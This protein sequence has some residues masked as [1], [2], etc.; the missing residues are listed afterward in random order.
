MSLLNILKSL[1]RF[2]FFF[3]TCY[4]CYMMTEKKH[5]RYHAGEM[6]SVKEVENF[7]SKKIWKTS[8]KKKKKNWNWCYSS[9]GWECKRRVLMILQNVFFF[10]LSL[11][12]LYMYS[13]TS[14]IRPL[15]ISFFASSYIQPH[16]RWK[17][18]IPNEV[19]VGGRPRK[20][21]RASFLLLL[22]LFLS[23][24]WIFL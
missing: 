14:R 24:A 11:S 20:T 10:F 16:R 21:N 2:L 5:V 9:M 13:Y 3:F 23:V 7:P 1:Y 19:E 4:N 17:R 6:N 15:S 18:L 12:S 22:L 8:Q